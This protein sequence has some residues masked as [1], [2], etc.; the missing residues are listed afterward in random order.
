VENNKDI[1]FTELGS[2]AV[3]GGNTTFY[4]GDQ[5]VLDKQDP[6]LFFQAASDVISDNLSGIVKGVFTY[7]WSLSDEEAYDDGHLFL[8]N[9]QPALAVIA[10][11][12]GNGRII[13]TIKKGT[14]LPDFIYASDYDDQ[15]Y[16]GLGADTIYSFKGNDFIDTNIIGSE[17]SY[18][19]ISFS[20]KSSILD[21]EAAKLEF[22]LNGQSR[23]TVSLAPDIGGYFSSFGDQPYTTI[24]DFIFNIDKM[25]TIESVEIYHRND[26]YEGFG[27]DLN[28]RVIDLQINGISLS[29]EHGAYYS[30]A[31]PNS[32][33][34]SSEQW[35]M[36]DS[37]KLVFDPSSINTIINERDNN[38]IDGGLGR[39]TIKYYYD[40]AE[41][42][43]SVLSNKSVQV[44]KPEGGIDSLN[45]VERLQGNDL[46]LAFDIEGN[47]GQAYRIYEA[48]FNR[49][50]DPHG[51]GYWIS[52]FDKGMGL[53]E[54]SSRFIDSNEFKSIY[55]T[56]P[57]NETFI[58]NLYL[59][60]L[61]RVP[62]NSGLA[63][64]VDQLDNNSEKTW[65]K[66]LADFSE[67]PEN[68]ENNRLEL[69]GGVEYNS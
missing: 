1:Y 54:I 37:G 67:S 46:S 51:L 61:D 56:N 57:T 19:E 66:V 15:I 53:I 8:V 36:Y 29:K 11:W 24:Q 60:V 6:T 45:N 65:E 5:T 25:I 7:A 30:K 39:D 12:F 40:L 32:I 58:T 59:N 21:G 20:I 2:P 64:W 63:W 9:H 26:R 18:N 16:M 62:D 68:I 52:Q 3:A 23:G 50:P 44:V 42:S 55:G 27:R 47:A 10:D 13:N 49:D 31:Q 22:I 38:Q 34:T 33:S 17:N 35:G 28:A 48:A 14:D 69:V 43:I 4:S 41:I